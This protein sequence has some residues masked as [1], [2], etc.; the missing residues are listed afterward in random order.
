MRACMQPKKKCADWEHT[1]KQ[2]RENSVGRSV[3]LVG[4]S[5]GLDDVLSAHTNGA[6]AAGCCTK[7]W[8]LH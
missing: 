4:R 7:S 5:V 8:V 1:S 3:G 2:T 6:L